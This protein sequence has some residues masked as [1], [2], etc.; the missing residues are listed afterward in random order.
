MIYFV[1]DDDNIRGLSLYALRQQVIEAE[2]FS[3]VSVF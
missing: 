2:G 3:C 1:E